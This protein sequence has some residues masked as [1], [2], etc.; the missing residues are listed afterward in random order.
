M[1]D[2]SETIVKVIEA[3]KKVGPR[4]CSLIS[5]MTGIPTETVRYKI[6]NQLI[7]KGISFRVNVNYARLG[8]IRTWAT[9]KFNRKIT[10]YAHL[11]LNS[12]AE[13][14]YLIY[15]ARSLL[16][17]SYVA[18]FAIPREF[19]MDYRKL[20]DKLVEIGILS[21]YEFDPLIQVDFV[22]FNPKYYDFN[23]RSWKIDWRKIRE[24][25]RG[26]FN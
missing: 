1:N 11:I 17:E 19:I 4:N 8:L 26:V 22:Q 10:N 2:R 6:K 14:A 23:F 20:L 25:E 16:D 3:I 18:M 13:N 7:K 9:F 12:M 24:K 21:S 5:R 15:Y